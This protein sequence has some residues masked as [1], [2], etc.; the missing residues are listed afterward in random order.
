VARAI[1][2]LVAPRALVFAN[3]VVVVLVDRTNRDHA[4]LLVLAHD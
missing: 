2:F 3:R 1:V 4:D